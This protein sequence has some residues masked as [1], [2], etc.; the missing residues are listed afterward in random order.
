MSSWEKVE[1]IRQTTQDVIYNK[2]LPRDTISRTAIHEEMS[3]FSLREAYV[4]ADSG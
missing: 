3:F 4:L 2:D 1:K